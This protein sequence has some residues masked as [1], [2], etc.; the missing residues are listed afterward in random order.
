VLLPV[1]GNFP[2]SLSWLQLLE[3]IRPSEIPYVKIIVMVHIGEV[4][5]PNEDLEN[6]DILRLGNK[7]PQ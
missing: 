5:Q 1:V 6:I 4:E 2:A 7:L 3:P